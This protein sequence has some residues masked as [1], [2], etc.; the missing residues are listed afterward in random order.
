[1]DSG[2]WQA[3]V[4]G[5]AKSRT[6]LSDYIF[7]FLSSA[8]YSGRYFTPFSSLPIFTWRDGRSAGQNTETYHN[9]R[10]VDLL[11]RRA[12]CGLI[13][14]SSAEA[15]AGRCVVWTLRLVS[16]L[17]WGLCNWWLSS[18]VLSGRCQS[19]SLSFQGS[20]AQRM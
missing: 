2:A 1:M 8:L 7:T 3:T 10:A 16:A 14:P 17:P 4:Y 20:V 19:A 5:V 11:I 9:V 15:W 12:G 18:I 6:R 13:S